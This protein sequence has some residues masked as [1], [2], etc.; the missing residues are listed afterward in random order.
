MEDDMP[1]LPE[2]AKNLLSTMM[3]AAQGFLQSGKIVAPDYIIQQRVETC[4]SCE[5]LNVQK[6]KCSKCGCGYK[7]KATLDKS[8][9]P[10]DK[11]DNNSMENK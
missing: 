10:L 11:W 4:L 7:K 8:K 2:Q 9:C 1:A 6:M 3:D 5:F